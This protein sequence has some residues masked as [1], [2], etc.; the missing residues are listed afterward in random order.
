MVIFGEPYPGAHG[1]VSHVHSFKPLGLFCSMI[2]SRVFVRCE[3]GRLLTKT[4]ID[5]DIRRHYIYP[6]SLSYEA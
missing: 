4:K 1:G 3:P 5:I 6:Y 2:S